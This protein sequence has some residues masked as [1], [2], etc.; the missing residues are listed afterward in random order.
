MHFNKILNKYSTISHLYLIYYYVIARE[1]VCHL[2]RPM[3]N[4]LVD[5]LPNIDAKVAIL[6]PKTH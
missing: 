2:K 6:F 3:V 4:N 1:I 5:V